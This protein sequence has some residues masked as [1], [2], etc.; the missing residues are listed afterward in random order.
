MGLLAGNCGKGHAKINQ[1]SSL[2]DSFQTMSALQTQGH[3]LWNNASVHCVNVY[4]YD[5]FNNQVGWPT[6]EQNKL[7]WE[8]QTEND[9]PP[10]DISQIK[11]GG[12]QEASVRSEFLC[13]SAL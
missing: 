6:A 9:I 11:A 2:R 1:A 13:Y 8:I 10:I 4:C 7:R 12:E 5:W 3:L